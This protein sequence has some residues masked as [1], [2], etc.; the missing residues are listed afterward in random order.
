VDSRPSTI[1]G[2]PDGY[3]IGGVTHG[4]VVPTD[5]PRA[6]VW[7]SPGGASWTRVGPRRAFHIGGYINTGEAA[8]SGGIAAVAAVPGGHVA[9]GD[10]CPPGFVDGGWLNSFES[11]PPSCFGQTWFGPEEG[12]WSRIETPKASDIIAVAALGA[13]VVAAASVCHDCPPIMLIADVGSPDGPERPGAWEFAYGS[14]VGGR[15]LDLDTAFDRFWALLAGPDGTT[16]ALWASDD[17]THWELREPLVLLP[18]AMRLDPHF[19]DVDLVA[20]PD[21]IVIVGSGR[22]RSF[23]VDVPMAGFLEPPP[24]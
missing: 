1:L 7:T 5:P 18:R 13:R 23:A 2:T 3:V 21:R 16:L 6:V 15:L 4:P 10:A 9:V 12:G 22:T 17:G 11:V 20:M 19:G 8:D 24:G 14:P